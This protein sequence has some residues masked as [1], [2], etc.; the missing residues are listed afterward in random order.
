MPRFQTLLAAV[1]AVGAIVLTGCAT[2]QDVEEVRADLR[3]QIAQ[4]NQAQQDR[5]RAIQAQLDKLETSQQAQ[6]QRLQSLE[7]RV[8]E[9][10]KIPGD[11]EGAVKAA[12]KYARDVE[13]SI[14]SL[15][16]LTARE[17]DRQNS[18]IR[19]VKA[20]YKSVLE[21]EIQA[22]SSMS[23][24]LDAVM[25]DLK[26]TLENSTKTLGEAIPG[27]D[28]TLPPAPRLPEGLKIEGGEGTAPA[29]PER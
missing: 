19:K 11:L 3:A 14:H 7:S 2:P 23:N 27:S 17:L 21:Q 28:E 12:M 6:S 15:R 29:P 20:S 8:E 26:T 13:K 1:L 25:G 5:L 24:A 16:Q 4:G 22:V 10:A 18:H 9:V